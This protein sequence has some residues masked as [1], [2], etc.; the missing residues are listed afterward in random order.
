MEVLSLPKHFFFR[1]VSVLWLVS[2]LKFTFADNFAVHVM[3]YRFI[4]VSMLIFFLHFCLGISEEEDLLV[5]Y[6]L[7]R[8]CLFVWDI[9][10]HDMC[11]G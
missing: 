6:L 8:M 1:M 4:C 3:L 7:C 11:S 9:R 5:K 2:H 10:K